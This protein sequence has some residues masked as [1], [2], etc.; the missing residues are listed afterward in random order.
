MKSTVKKLVI[1]VGLVASVVPVFAQDPNFSLKNK[2]K[3]AIYVTVT[4]YHHTV[5]MPMINGKIHNPKTGFSNFQY[6]FVQPIVLNADRALMLDLPGDQMYNLNI[7]YD[8]ALNEYMYTAFDII[9]ATNNSGTFYVKFETKKG[10]L[11]LLPQEG[12]F[13]KTTEGYSLKKNVRLSKAQKQLGSTMTQKPPF[14]SNKALDF[15]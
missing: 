1:I 6:D 14:D 13:G 2:T 7:V 5:N 8:P 11:V 3:Q 15:E 10:E 9:P 12:R 4:P